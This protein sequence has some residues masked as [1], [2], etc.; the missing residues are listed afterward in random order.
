MRLRLIV[1]VMEG[2]VLDVGELADC[3]ADESHAAI[4]RP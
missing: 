3:G 4:S 1:S 2:G